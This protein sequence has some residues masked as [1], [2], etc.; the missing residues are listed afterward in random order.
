MTDEEVMTHVSETRS[1]WT[2]SV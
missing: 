1:Y 2:D